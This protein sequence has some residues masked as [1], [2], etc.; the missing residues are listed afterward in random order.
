MKAYTYKTRRQQSTPEAKSKVADYSV[1]Y[2]LMASDSALYSSLQSIDRG[3]GAYNTAE[4][5]ELYAAAFMGNE[6]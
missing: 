4:M 6:L 1:A 3:D 2:V 5:M